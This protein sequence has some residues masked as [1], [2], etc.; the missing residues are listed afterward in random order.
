VDPSKEEP[1]RQRWR[2]H[3]FLGKEGKSES[4]FGERWGRLSH[5]SPEGKLRIL[6]RGEPREKRGR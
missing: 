6:D 2:E 3:A 5:L 1:L 4:N